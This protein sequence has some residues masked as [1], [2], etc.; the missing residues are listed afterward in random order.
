M[1]RKRRRKKVQKEEVNWLEYF[2]SIRR[3]C[4]WSLQSFRQGK[5]EFIEFDGAWNMDIGQWDA[6]V[7]IVDRKARL[8]K[9]WADQ[10]NDQDPVC[11]WLWSHPKYKNYSAPVPIIIQQPRAKLE[12]LRRKNI[13]LD[14]V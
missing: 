13:Q 10:L 14:D 4:P 3:V 11:E 8:I 1:V 2:Q 6:R 9:K 5:I 12:E 7:Y